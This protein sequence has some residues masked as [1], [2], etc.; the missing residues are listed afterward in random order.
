MKKSNSYINDID[1]KTKD[2]TKF[3]SMKIAFHN[4][5]KHIKSNNLLNCFTTDK[6]A[7]NYKKPKKSEYTLILN[8]KK[9]ELNNISKISNNH[10]FMNY[11]KK[12]N[13]K[14]KKLK[15]NFTTDNN[16]NGGIMKITDSDNSSYNYNGKIGLNAPLSYKE[17][18]SN[19][20][21]IDEISNSKKNI[22]NI[23]DDKNNTK[24]NLKK[25][26][27][28]IDKS[29]I[30]KKE[31]KNNYKNEN[32][33]DI[34]TNIIKHKLIKRNNDNNNINHSY[35]NNK[36]NKSSSNILY[37][38][39]N[40]NSY[41]KSQR[42]NKVNKDNIKTNFSYNKSYDNNKNLNINNNSIFKN[43]PMGFH[44]AMN[45]N[46]NSKNIKNKNNSFISNNLKIYKNKSNLQKT[47]E[48]ISSGTISLDINVNYSTSTNKK[49]LINSSY[50]LTK[51]FISNKNSHFK[52]NLQKSSPSKQNNIS[53]NNI[54]KS[55]LNSI[56]GRTKDKTNRT[57]DKRN[58][59]SI[60]NKKS[61]YNEKNKN[62]QN[63]IQKDDT[64][65][66]SKQN[67]YNNNK[68]K[69]MDNG[70]NYRKYIEGN[71]RNNVG[72]KIYE[73]ELLLK[74]KIEK[75][76][77]DMRKKK[78]EDEM[79]EVRDIP[80]INDISKKISKNNLPIY[81][82]L[83]EIENKKKINTQKI[84]ELIISE[85]EITVNTI[86]DKCS[87]NV[88]DLKS[89]NDWYL[90]N[91]NWYNKKNLKIE[92][93]KNIINQE[94]AENEDYNFKPTI[95]KNSE[96]IFYNRYIYN[97]YSVLDR[98]N[99]AK[100]TKESSIKKI[101]EEEL[102]PFKPDIN[103]NYQIRNKYYEFM[104]EDQAEIYQELKEKIENEEKKL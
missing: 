58:N 45:K 41:Y 61:C 102:L 72:V 82:R 37:D 99:K 19:N 39:I 40:N 78:I 20:F 70:Y 13:E 3:E 51:K 60:N 95:D 55:P 15:N 14:E 34:K 97:K 59:I 23:R 47:E 33:F 6:F 36:N 18:T 27:V 76:L 69:S 10:S 5:L 21:S 79:S 7:Q 67:T 104:E 28:Y 57:I 11:N 65:N 86:N 89:F 98:L 84:K 80:K 38:V 29:N 31:G 85:T 54:S 56:T 8:Q 74:E 46:K 16:I 68:S 94:K 92:K 93:I 42:K 50:N 101:K 4:P 48:S 100:E 66:N 17:L 88:F 62:K 35:N 103:N 22:N 52:I 75:K 2:N 43:I 77:N 64:K 71:Q 30:K 32:F 87:K 96:K 26:E 24:N 63:I 90:S 81:K 53:E 91:E 1:F 83:N 44:S 9:K 25:D 12:V 49:N 73:R